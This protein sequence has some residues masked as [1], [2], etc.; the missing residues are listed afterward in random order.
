[1]RKKARE[2]GKVG[3][4]Q[5]WEETGKYTEGQRCLQTGILVWGLGQDTG[6]LQLDGT[7]VTKKKIYLS[8]SFRKEAR[9]QQDHRRSTWT[10]AA[11]VS[12]GRGP[13]LASAQRRGGSWSVERVWP[14]LGPK[15]KG[16][17][18]MNRGTQYHCCS[19][20]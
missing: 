2:R 15:V 20:I 3:L 17:L 16:L 18:D 9:I 4:D 13:M 10:L 11:K 1:M 19:N 5:V 14:C 7:S 8:N 6:E 12:R